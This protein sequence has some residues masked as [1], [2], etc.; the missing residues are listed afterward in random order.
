MTP[1]PNL[2]TL[3]SSRHNLIAFRPPESNLISIFHD[4]Q[5]LEE[6]LNNHLLVPQ[7][8]IKKK[9]DAMKKSPKMLKT[10]VKTETG[11]KQ[12]WDELLHRIDILAG[13]TATIHCLPLSKSSNSSNPSY[14]YCCYS[15]LVVSRLHF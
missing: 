12:C 1:D 5:C 14:S 9:K 15:C 7:V 3:R 4:N 11:K 13:L 8:E 10:P 2:I 6:T